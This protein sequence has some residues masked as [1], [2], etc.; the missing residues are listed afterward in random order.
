[1]KKYFFALAAITFSTSAFSAPECKQ[2]KIENSNIE[3]C[4]IRGESFQHDIY[5]LKADK[6]VIF[7]LTDDYVENIS[8][9]HTI[10][11]G[12]AIEFPLSKQGGKNV[13]ITGGCVPEIKD[14]AE[15]ARVCNFYWGKYPVVKD[16]RFEFQ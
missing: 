3:M 13:K 7:A 15:I 5:M 12:L 11:D 10:P 1:M 14:D 9:E 8:L 16:V 6:V 4:L 2:E